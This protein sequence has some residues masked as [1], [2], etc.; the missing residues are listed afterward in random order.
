MRLFLHK[1]TKIE[2]NDLPTLS[3]ICLYTAA[4]NGTMTDVSQ[5]VEGKHTQIK[6]L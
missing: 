6:G 1:S 5:Q 2:D 4:I 3:L